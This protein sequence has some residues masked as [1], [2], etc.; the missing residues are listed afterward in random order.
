MAYDP[1]L[2]YIGVGN[3]SPWNQASPRAADNLYLS[4]IVAIRAKTGPM[5]GI[6]GNAGRNL[7]LHRTQH[8]MLADLTIGKPRKVLM[9]A[10]KN[11]FF[12]VLD[13]QTGQF[14]SATTSCR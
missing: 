11:G 2:L 7:G 12:Y 10:P 14:L 13:R 4:S 9:H 8:I 1:D 5:S 3:G 6:P